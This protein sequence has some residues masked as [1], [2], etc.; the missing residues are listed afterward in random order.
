MSKGLSYPQ[1]KQ[2]Y[3]QKK[4]GIVDNFFY[5]RKL[6]VGGLSLALCKMIDLLWTFILS[7][8]HKDH[9]KG[10]LSMSDE[11]LQPISAFEWAS[12][13]QYIVYISGAAQLLEVNSDH[14]RCLRLSKKGANTL[15]SQK[16]RM[17][18]ILKTN[19]RRLE[20]FVERFRGQLE[21]TELSVIRGMYRQLKDNLE[22]VERHMK[23]IEN[24]AK[25]SNKDMFEQSEAEDETPF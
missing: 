4:S 3:P 25:S 10:N 22:T 2:S 1:K 16:L 24:F 7:A 19:L 18:V 15:L 11:K 17:S 9:E 13:T 5:L 8:K 20:G 21:S 23:T 14:V 12:V 6:Y